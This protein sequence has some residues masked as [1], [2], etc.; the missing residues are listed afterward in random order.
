MTT[1]CTCGP[2][3]SNGIPDIC[4]VPAVAPVPTPFPNVGLNATA[5]PGCFTIL[6]SGMPEL[7]TAGQYPITNGDQP[8]AIGGVTSGTIMGPGRPM[9]GSQAVFVCGQPVWR[10]MDPTMQNSTNA[11]GTTMVPSQTTKK[12]MR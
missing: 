4:L 6:N 5:I 9:M 10:V 8:G 12:V 2:G 1:V 3:M 11:P 7:T